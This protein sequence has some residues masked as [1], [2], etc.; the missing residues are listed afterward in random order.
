LQLV[1]GEITAGNNNQ[2]LLGE[3]YELLYKISDFG[4]ISKKHFNQ[5]KSAY[6]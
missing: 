2:E 4:A 5:I 6:F 3:L 1:E